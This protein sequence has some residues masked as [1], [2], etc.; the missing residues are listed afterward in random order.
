MVTDPRM[1]LSQSSKER[2]QK[3]RGSQPRKYKLSRKESLKMDSTE[4]KE[5][6]GLSSASKLS[7]YLFIVSGKGPREGGGLIGSPEF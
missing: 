2:K 1:A 6:R 3:E 7:Y 4:K 5:R